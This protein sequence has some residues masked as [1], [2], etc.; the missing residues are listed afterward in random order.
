MMPNKS[1][2]DIAI[3]IETSN[4]TKEVLYCFLFVDDVC[5]IITHD[6]AMELIHKLGWTVQDTT[7]IL[8]EHTNIYYQL[9][10]DAATL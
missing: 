8:D 5:I 10:T 6:E 9:I 2:H 1:Q 7:D 4:S 3:H